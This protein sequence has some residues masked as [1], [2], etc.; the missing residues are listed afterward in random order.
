EIVVADEAEAVG[1]DGHR[2]VPPD[3]A[4]AVKGGGG[5]RGAG[6]I[7]TVGDLQIEV[8][9]NIE[10]ADEPEAVGADGHRRELADVSGAVDRRHGIVHWRRAHHCRS[11]LTARAL[12]T[13]RS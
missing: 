12:C 8:A 6:D 4:G 5:R 1:A 2:R 11:R 7:V 9:D 13:L 10:V 3:L